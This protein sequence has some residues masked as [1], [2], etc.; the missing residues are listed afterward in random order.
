MFFWM[1]YNDKIVKLLA[2][3]NL[4]QI[5]VDRT[6]LTVECYY[7]EKQGNVRRKLGSRSISG[8]TIKLKK[9][10]NIYL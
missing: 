1:L 4:K 3:Y 8:Q 5:E 9:I 10:Y 2:F 7:Q 6:K